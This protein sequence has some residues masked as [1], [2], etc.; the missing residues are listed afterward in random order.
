MAARTLFKI[1]VAFV[2]GLLGGSAFGDETLSQFTAGSELTGEE[3][4]VL[5]EQLERDAH[6]LPIRT[7]LLGYYYNSARYR[8]QSAQDQK[9]KHLLWLIRNAPEAGVLLH[10]S[11]RIEPFRSPEDY[12]DSKREWLRHVE[13][14][15]E[16]LT[17]LE[18]AAGFLARHDRDIALDLLHRAQSLDESNPIWAMKLGSMYLRK[19][20][21]Y[22]GE[23]SVPVAR[24]ALA[25]LERS[26][27]LSGEDG[28]QYLLE[29]LSK[30][31]LAANDHG[32]AR[33][34]AR[35]M[36][37]GNY[38]AEKNGDL[39]HHGHLTL[40]K[41]ALAEGDVAQAKDRLLMA[42]KA[43]R[44]RKLR[45]AGPNMALAKE[46][47]ERGQKKI[48]LKYFKLC[49]KFWNTDRAKDKLDEWSVLAAAGRIPDFGANLVY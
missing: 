39:I 31:A 10:I 40:G 34:Y 9:R 38:S 43:P 46:L 30:A 8:D 3:A 2:F 1:T 49:A 14:E 4:T 19:A 12:V 48:V 33:E 32:R 35:L 45:Y 16:N 22:R 15:P 42:G 21:T 44:S 20:R 29:N 41:I 36:L 18:H 27:E 11:R 5:E 47:L 37:K 6:N 25:Q 17:L 23:V 7:Q 28:Q 13:R 26:Y 24:Q